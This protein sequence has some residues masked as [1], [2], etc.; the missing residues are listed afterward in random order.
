[1][2][3]EINW[4]ALTVAMGC[5]GFIQGFAG[6]GFGLVS[7]SLL[8]FFMGIKQAA[9]LSTTFMLLATITTFA[10]HC[11]DYN[12]RLGAMFLVSVAVGLPA[13]VFFLEKSGERLLVK[14]LGGL[15]LAYALREFIVPSQARRFP[16]VLTIPLGLFSGAMSGAFN[17]GGIP[18]AAY[19]Y[20]Q[21]WARG[22]I[23]AFLQVMMTLSGALRMI[24][25]DKAGLLAGIPWGLAA[26]PA[27][28]VLA[29]IWL[30]HFALQRVDPRHMRRGIFVLI[31]VCGAYYL[32]RPR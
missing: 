8:P 10:R 30:G 13:G 12:W 22:Q 32:V 17:L 27:L 25:Y 26:L 2:R 20:A 11:R 19:A 23:I 21:P 6:F 4:F 31:A 3:V 28:G 18:T 9:I 14:C 5:A 16:A 24:F 1:M 29:G 15:M 7:M